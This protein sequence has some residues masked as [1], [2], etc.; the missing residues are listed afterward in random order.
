MFCPITTKYLVLCYKFFIQ[1]ALLV[2]TGLTAIEA[3]M[4]ACILFVFGTL[5]EYA[6]I[7]FAM[8]IEPTPDQC[9]SEDENSKKHSKGPA[10]L[11]AVNTQLDTQSLSHTW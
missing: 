10:N 3:W 1:F 5:T 2:G 4:L 7:L 11:D 9:T 8:G 6:G